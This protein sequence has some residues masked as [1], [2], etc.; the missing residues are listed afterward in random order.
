VE[1]ARTSYRGEVAKGYEAHRVTGVEWEAEQEAVLGFVTS[2]PVLDV[3]VGT[4]RYLPIYH[5]YGMECVGV[6]I[7]PDM[8]EQAKQK[9]T[10]ARLLIGDIFNLPF[11]DGEFSAAVCSRFLNWCN[12]DEMARA[13]KELRR[14]ART[15]IVSIRTGKEG[16]AGNYTHDLAKFY[17][18]IEGLHIRDRRVI[19][20]VESGLFEM[21]KLTPPDLYTVMAQF[22][23]LGGK[24]WLP[25]KAQDWTRHF[26]LPDINW[27]RVE[28]FS[29]YWTHEDLRA[30]LLEMAEIPKINGVPNEIITSD[31]PRRLSGPLTVLRTDGREVMLDGRRRANLWMNTPGR[32]P[33]LVVSC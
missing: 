13:I 29:E 10:D 32:Y 4:G 1:V 8:L 23:E 11:K 24:N 5:G 18:A 7:S 20:R 25:K 27:D 14:V 21:F 12:P 31:P 33:V 19:S 16:V 9:G 15:L 17:E 26:G 3:P 28:I 30:L 6:D 22:G 2:G